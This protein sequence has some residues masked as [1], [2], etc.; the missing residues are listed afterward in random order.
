MLPGP[1]ADFPIPPTYIGPPSDEDRI[2]V[3]SE[4]TEAYEDLPI[5]EQIALGVTPAGVMADLMMAAKYGRDTLEEF[6][7]ENHG[8]AA[9]AGT[10]AALSM[11]GFIPGVGDALKAGGQKLLRGLGVPSSSARKLAQKPKARPLTEAEKSVEE[12]KKRMLGTKKQQKERAELPETLKEL[13]QGLEREEIGFGPELDKAIRAL[14]KKKAKPR[15]IADW[16]PEEISFEDFKRVY[17]EASK[18]EHKEMLQQLQE[19]LA[20]AQHRRTYPSENVVDLDQ[21]HGIRRGIENLLDPRLLRQRQWLFEEYG[22]KDADLAKLTKQM[23]EYEGMGN[24]L[25]T[26]FS[27]RLTPQ[28][29]RDITGIE[30]GLPLDEFNAGGEIEDESERFELGIDWRDPVDEDWPLEGRDYIVD[31]EGN[32][33][34]AHNVEAP[35]SFR[36]LL[37][38]QQGDE[39]RLLLG[40]KLLNSAPSFPLEAMSR[41]KSPKDLKSATRPRKRTASSILKLLEEGG[42]QSGRDFSDRDYEYF[43]TLL[44][45][46]SS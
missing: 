32:W 5:W 18:P 1:S 40:E 20:A 28:D 9:V 15:S 44:E 30:G 38:Q 45:E 7:A 25:G 46:E 22:L 16:W 13:E 36:E 29:L 33:I 41:M 23:Q 6:I 31:R 42:D 26:D 21:Y 19:E 10:M 14:S 3:L 37:E 43:M 2:D 17:P 39:L 27:R 8:A 4:G 12:W 34:W 11:V 24:V 35:G